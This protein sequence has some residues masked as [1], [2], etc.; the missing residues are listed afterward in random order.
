MPGDE[1][2]AQVLAR[3]RGGRDLGRIDVEAVVAGHDRRRDL[4]DRLGQPLPLDS[5]IVIEQG[6]GAT[7]ERRL[8]AGIEQ[9]AGQ[10]DAKDAR[11]GGGAGAGHP[12][13]LPA[14][15]ASIAPT[16]PR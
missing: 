15:P 9:G 3:D 5:R 12:C 14:V 2:H 8:A 1:L 16:R 13:P 10:A 7:A 6:Q 11:P 4:A